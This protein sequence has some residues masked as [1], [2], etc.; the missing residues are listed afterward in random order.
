MPKPLTA[1]DVFRRLRDHDSA[2]VVLIRRGK[3]SHRLIYHPDTDRAFTIPYHKG[4]TLGKGLLHKLI[5]RFDLPKD[6]FG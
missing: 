3:G 6:I 2:F 1:D 5:R 4:R